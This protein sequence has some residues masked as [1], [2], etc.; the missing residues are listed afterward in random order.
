[1]K[2]SCI[3]IDDEPLALEVIRNYAQKN[4]HLHV[5]DC[6]DNVL[7][8]EKFLAQHPTD[9]V[10]VDINMPDKNGIE[11]VSALPSKTLVIFTTAHKK[12]ALQAFDLHAVDYLLK[13][14]QEERFHNAIEK[15][16]T[17]TKGKNKHDDDSFIMVY[18]E[19]KLVKIDLNAI[20]FVESMQ[21]YIRIHLQNEKPVMTLQTLKKISELLPAT[22]FQQVHRSYIVALDK[23]KSIQQKNIELANG[24]LV[25][26]GNSFIAVIKS[27]KERSRF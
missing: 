2:L 24:I 22:K 15:A 26:V 23:I 1:M 14:I 19:Y 21:D 10:L 6:F 12:F 16:V 5:L 11:F 27:Y 25:P 4:E 8:A 20:V 9:L 13:P 3:A 17:I 7:D 18:A